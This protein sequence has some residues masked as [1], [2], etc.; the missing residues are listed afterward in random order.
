MES[1]LKGCSKLVETW[2]G[3]LKKNERCRDV[4]W[5]CLPQ[6]ITRLLARQSHG[7]RND[8]IAKA[9]EI[10]QGFVSEVIT[11]LQQGISSSIVESPE[12]SLALQLW[13]NYLKRTGS[14]LQED[15]SR[16]TKKPRIDATV[17]R[18]RQERLQERLTQDRLHVT[19]EGQRSSHRYTHEP[20]VYDTHQRAFIKIC[21]TIQMTQ[22]YPG[23]PPRD[24]LIISRTPAFTST[25][26]S[27][28]KDHCDWVESIIISRA[29]GWQSCV[30]LKLQFYA[31]FEESTINESFAELICACHLHWELCSTLEKYL[32]RHRADSTRM[33]QATFQLACE[34]LLSVFSKMEKLRTLLRDHLY[35]VSSAICKDAR[36][37]LFGSWDLWQLNVE[38]LLTSTLNQM[39]ASEDSSSVPPQT[40]DALVKIS[41]IAPYHVVSKIVH[42]AAVNKGQGPLFL[43]LLLDLGQLVWLKPSAEEPTLFL[44]VI[45]DII[46]NRDHNWVISEKAPSWTASQLDNFARTVEGGMS[47]RSRSGVLLLDPLEFLKYCAMPLLREME[48]A[49]GDGGGGSCFEV[50]TKVILAIYQPNSAIMAGYKDWFSHDAHFELLTALLHLQTLKS[51]WS[52]DRLYGNRRSTTSIPRRGGQHLDSVANMCEAVVSRLATAIEASDRKMVNDQQARVAMFLDLL[53][54]DGA[55]DVESKLGVTPLILACRSYMAPNLE[56]PQLPV[57]ISVLCQ[58]PLWRFRSAEPEL[59]DSSDIPVALGLVVVFDIS[60]MCEELMQDIAQAI[61]VPSTSLFDLEATKIM[62]VAVLYRSMSI[63]TRSQSHRLFA[64]GVT[65]IMDMLGGIRLDD[66]TMLDEGSKEESTMTQLGSYWGE[67]VKSVKKDSGEKSLLTMLT[68]SQPLLQLA[69]NPLPDQHRD[70]LFQVYRYGLGFDVLVDQVASLIQSTLKSVI[71]DWPSMPL[72]LV[73]FSFMAVCRM[74]HTLATWQP[75]RRTILRTG[76][77]SVPTWDDIQ[78]HAKHP[79]QKLATL[80][81]GSDLDLD[82]VN[83]QDQESVALAK[84]RD[85]LVLM[86]MNF[87]E[88][89]V[90]RQDEYYQPEIQ[91]EKEQ[92]KKQAR[93]TPARRGRGRRQGHIFGRNVS[94]AFKGGD[95]VP[96]VNPA[97]AEYMNKTSPAE[98]SNSQYSSPQDSSAMSTLSSTPDPEVTAQDTPDESTPE[99]EKR[100]E[101]SPML[102]SDQQ[103]CLKL[104]L[105]F[106]PPQEQRAVRARLNRLLNHCT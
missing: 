14:S 57:E 65:A 31:V 97:F 54:K 6:L 93:S 106:L 13:F 36:A 69:L 25:G 12:H 76:P 34:L 10:I 68:V 8:T 104:A 16:P 44:L 79:L 46:N 18:S 4:F 40:V 102:S 50:V 72:D 15:I 17:S 71:V 11:Q 9:D 53:Q 30:K 56:I 88:E 83:C 21:E 29:I 47:T 75:G 66:I 77:D 3:V 92:K 63:C 73:L 32:R 85:E 90:R 43:Q 60:R 98:S 19:T 87:S 84:A 81:T 37:P 28:L 48:S 67:Y 94:Q 55:I 5:S 64:K 80:P 45:S 74:G 100:V 33:T 89:V 24:L 20:T 38:G 1:T 82:F 70:E 59:M 7:S 95:V 86:A 2:E 39:V 52:M 105:D 61:A 27:T 62:L 42:S 103:T 96:A 41:L 58:R 49:K 23:C 91:W 101:L 22:D 78:Y 26:E 35:H 51:P 99:V